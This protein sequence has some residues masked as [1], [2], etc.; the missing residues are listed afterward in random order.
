MDKP[1]CQVEGCIKRS[2]TRG[3]CPQ[4]YENW[5]A[6]G[7]PIPLRDMTVE[8]RIHL[9][10]WD[11]TDSGCWEWKGSRNDRNYGLLGMVRRGFK[12]ARVHRLMYELKIG[13]IP[14]GIIIRHKCDNPPCVNPDHLE[15]GT[16]ADNA[17]DMKARGRRLEWERNGMKCRNGHDV[18][19]RSN[20]TMVK[21][22]RTCALCS[23]DTKN[24]YKARKRAER[25]H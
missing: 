1:E 11:V 4:H 25:D 9:T 7:R 15:P 20:V 14:E 3:W 23:R 5:R 18:S 24:R 8:E 13:A 16:D 6:R 10:G 17:E 12:G 19:N 22:C 2:K 21:G